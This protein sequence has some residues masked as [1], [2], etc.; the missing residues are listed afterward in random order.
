[1]TTPPIPQSPTFYEILNITPT[2]QQSEVKEA[3][4]KKALLYHP[5]KNLGNR[6]A[7]SQFQKVYTTK[8]ILDI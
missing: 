4:R 6:S 7:V 5:D 3:Y 2:A 8:W 1:M